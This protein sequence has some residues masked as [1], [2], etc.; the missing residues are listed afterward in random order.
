MGNVDLLQ[1]GGKGGHH[2]PRSQRPP[3]ASSRYCCGDQCADV[4]NED[5]V[6][7]GENGNVT[8]SDAAAAAGEEEAGEGWRP[9]RR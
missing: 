6:A 9:G 2:S 1:W 3:V 4:D 8:T 5:D 7:H